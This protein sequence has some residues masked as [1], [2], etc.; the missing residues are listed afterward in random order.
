MQKHK[1]LRYTF[2]KYMQDLYTGNSQTLL[3]LKNVRKW[4]DTSHS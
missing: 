2:E 1:I 4:K 3:K